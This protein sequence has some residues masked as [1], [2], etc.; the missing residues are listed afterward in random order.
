[1]VVS[2]AA[3]REATERKP[4]EVF[5]L[6]AGVVFLVAGV[7]GFIPGVTTGY[8]ALEFGGHHSGAMLF[9]VFQVSILHNLV[10]LAFGVAGL[11]AFAT[12]A[13]ARAYLVL[14]GGIYLV[15]WLYGVAVSKAT[16]GNFIPVNSADNWL[17]L[18]LG[19]GMIGLG[20]LATAIERGQGTY[21]AP[22]DQGER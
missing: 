19:L 21:P 5:A 12:R 18:G 9:G 7:L 3:G 11:A 8:D 20:V 1:M 4:V 16:P 6:M 10:H 13:P 14:G 2:K 15:L 22:Q 17:H